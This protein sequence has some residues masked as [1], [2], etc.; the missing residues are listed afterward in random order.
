MKGEKESS[1]RV[2][3]ASVGTESHAEAKKRRLYTDVV[4]ETDGK[5]ARVAG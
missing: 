5:Q 2:F 4:L 3:W 1:G